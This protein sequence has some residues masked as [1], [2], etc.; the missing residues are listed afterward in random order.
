MMICVGSK[1]KNANFSSFTLRV[2][3]RHWQ[4][5]G[6]WFGVCKHLVF[7]CQACLVVAL[8][9][10][11]R[12]DLAWRARTRKQPRCPPPN[13]WINKMWYFYIYWTITQPKKE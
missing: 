6:K 5:G 2:P 10:D 9:W 7:T 8:H 3:L 4:T 11:R 12:M 13:Q 1:V